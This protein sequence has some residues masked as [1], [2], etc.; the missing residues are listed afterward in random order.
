MLFPA[1]PDE[2]LGNVG[3][4]LL[5]VTVTIIAQRPYPRQVFPDLAR[6]AAPLADGGRLLF[7]LV[8]EVEY[9]TRLGSARARH[10]LRKI[11]RTTRPR[12]P[13]PT[14]CTS[15]EGRRANPGIDSGI[16]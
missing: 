3:V 11:C 15:F 5:L 4:R 13:L 8:H 16:P 7:E 1:I 10:I 2:L 6:L 12:T 14:P 9:R